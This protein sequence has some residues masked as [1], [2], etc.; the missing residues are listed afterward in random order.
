[1]KPRGLS[2]I[3]MIIVLAIVGVFA[4]MVYPL[5]R[6]AI[7][8][9][10][11]ATCLTQLRTL[12][13]GLQ[14][15]LQEH[16]NTMP[17]LAIARNS[18]TDDVPV[19][20]TVLLPYVGSPETFHCAADAKLYEKSG[21]S[22]NWNHLQNG[23]RSSDLYFFNVEEDRIPLITD[24]EAWHPGGTNFLNADLSSS[25]KPRFVAESR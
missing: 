23:R 15:Y 14:G 10:R 8:K 13:T 18:K 11:E 16:D 24:K 7:A 21:S 22:Y 2:L 17:E 5:T 20:D 12:G 4:S 9:S 1:M 6:S 19:L 3:E 25:N